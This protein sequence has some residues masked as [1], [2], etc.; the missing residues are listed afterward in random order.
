[1]NSNPLT[2][3]RLWRVAA[4]VM[5]SFGSFVAHAQGTV[6]AVGSAVRDDNDVVWKRIVDLAGG[7]GARVAVFTAPAGEPDRAASEIIASLERR[8]A[9]AEHIRVGPRVPGQD[10]VAAVRDPAWV[11]KVDQARAVYFSGGNQARLID[12]LRPGGQESPLLQ[13]VQAL[14]K[15]GGVV[16]GESAGAAVMSHEIYRDPPQDPLA[17]LKI[18]LRPGLDIDQGLGFVRHDVIVDQHLI[19]RGRIG[20]LLRLMQLKDKPLGLGVE[21]HTA[22]VV[23]GDEVEV[24][25]HRGVLVVDQS[26]A[27]RDPALGTVFNLRGVRLW[28]LDHG[29]RF[30]L[31]TRKLTPAPARAAAQRLEI[32]A[33]AY[34]GRP[35]VETWGVAAFPDM[36][37][38]S[39]FVNAL[40]RLA[41]QGPAE[42][43]RDIVG[44][45]FSLRPAPDEVQ[46]DLGFEWRLRARPA[47]LAWR[48]RPD[49]YTIADVELDVVPVRMQRPLY[50]P[51]GR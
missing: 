10:V 16:A 46:P 7:P 48:E 45:S 21:E 32:G 15:R 13:A 49:R 42:R 17:P 22:V 39:M 44:L 30:D 36:L 20:R 8:G 19:R 34:A 28:L 27:Q 37:G 11:A 24:V 43:E 29:D 41:E 12:T 5:C 40:V 18:E 25:G 3:A 9:K 50:T 6:V 31:A 47:S 23:R 51:H 4:S 1:M 2:P 14:F 33:K 35:G 38:E 26:A